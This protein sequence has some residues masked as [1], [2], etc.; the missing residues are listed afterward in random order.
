MQILWQDMRYGARMLMKKP[1]FT[2]V[3]VITL[4]LGIGAN[5]AVFSVINTV[6]LKR[7]PYP[8]AENLVVIWGKLK[9][10]D[11]VELS[12]KEL[13]E[14]RERNRAFT[15]IG[16]GEGVNLN[17]TGGSEPLRVEGYAAT[18]NLFSVLGTKPILGRTFTAEEDRTNARVA[19][20]DHGLWQKRFAGKSGIIG[21]TIMLDGRNYTVIGVMP[22]EFEF[23]PP[24]SNRAHADIFLPRSIET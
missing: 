1:G 18:E 17:L 19:V 4:A 6:L 16:A 14:Y 7:L 23:P 3:A 2:L 8:N 24:I 22:Q 13:V 21:Q 5:T 12:P 11:Q 20:L 10:V 9:R 15:Q